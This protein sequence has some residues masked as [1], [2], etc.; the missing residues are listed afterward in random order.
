MLKMDVLD[1]VFPADYPD[2][3]GSC[4]SDEI[5]VHFADQMIPTKMKAILSPY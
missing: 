2:D 5:P 3:C 1:N 4:Q